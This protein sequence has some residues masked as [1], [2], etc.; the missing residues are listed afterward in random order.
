MPEGLEELVPEYFERQRLRASELTGLQAAGDYA[1]IRRIAHEMK[2]TGASYGFDGLS[3]LAAQLEGTI[4]DESF[5]PVAELIGEIASYLG[6]A[7][8]IEAS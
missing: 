8:L 7:R 4:R 1:A 5:A 6:R 2:G 3:E